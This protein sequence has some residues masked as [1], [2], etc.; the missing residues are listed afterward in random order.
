MIPPKPTK[1]PIDFLAIIKRLQSALTKQEQKYT[2]QVIEAYTKSYKTIQPHIEKVTL[3]IEAHPD[4]TQTGIKR[5]KEYRDLI[6]VTE[7]E[8]NSFV[9]YARTTIGIAISAAALLSLNSVSQWGMTPVTPDALEVVTRFLQP[10][11]ALYDRIGLWA[12][13]ARE[14]VIQSIIEGVGLGKNPRTIAQEITRAFGTSLTDAVRTTR[15]SQLWAARES[16]R[17]NY[18]ANGITQWIWMA[19]LDELTCGACMELHGKVFDTDTPLEGHYNCRCTMI[20]NTAYEA[21]TQTSEDF[22]NSLS[23]EQQNKMLGQGKAQL[24]RDGDISLKFLVT[25]V[26]DPVYGHMMTETPLKD[27]LPDE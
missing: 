25:R 18:I 8:L 19:E 9:D 14:G 27:L 7:K 4:I 10:D 24:L 1:K 5:S 3:F 12:G 26:E 2:N 20:P 15:T 21:I 23:E 11:T 17:L 22:F 6:D 13:N 16:T